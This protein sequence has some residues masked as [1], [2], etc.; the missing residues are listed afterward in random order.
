MNKIFN[1]FFGIHESVQSHILINYFNAPSTTKD[2]HLGGQQPHSVAISS[3]SLWNTDLLSI[4]VIYF[5]NYSLNYVADLN[6]I[7]DPLDSAVND[8]KRKKLQ[9]NA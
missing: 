7:K 8:S 2:I 4:A 1:L 3:L 6:G 5:T 9:A